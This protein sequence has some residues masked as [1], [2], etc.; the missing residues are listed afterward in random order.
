M[1]K[2]TPRPRGYSSKLRTDAASGTRNGILD[3]AKALMGAKGIDRVTIAG[4]GARAGVAASTIYAIFRSKEGIIRALMQQ[5]LFGGPFQ[6]A[7]KMLDDV[8]D[9][10]GWWN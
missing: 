8:T 1:N 3:A 7:Q 9:P 5:S 6:T 4:I 2:S 10:V